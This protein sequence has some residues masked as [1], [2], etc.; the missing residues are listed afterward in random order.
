M[1]ARDK[2][3]NYLARFSRTERQVADYLAR[4][5]F[6]PEEIRAAISFLREHKFVDDCAFAE[7]FLQSRLRL[8]DGPLK[9]RQML[10]QKGIAKSLIDSLLKEQ[11]P[12][13][14]QI[15]NAAAL[16]EKRMSRRGAATIERQKLYRFLA[17]RGFTGYV[18]IQ[19]FRQHRGEAK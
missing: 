15:E 3:L 6:P 19:A 11:Y 9:I 17:S 14:L 18:I 2:A 5:E 4:K 12:S 8:F 7:S 1:S 13:E 10:L 16:L